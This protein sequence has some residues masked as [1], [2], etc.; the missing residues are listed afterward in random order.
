MKVMKSMKRAGTGTLDGQG[1]VKGSGWLMLCSDTGM[2]S[3]N[4]LHFKFQRFQLNC[5]MIHIAFGN[6]LCVL[7]KV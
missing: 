4:S 1:R 5:V 6:L 2:D 3:K 7:L